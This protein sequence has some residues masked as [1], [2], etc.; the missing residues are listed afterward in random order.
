MRGGQE[1]FE[2][3]FSHGFERLQWGEGVFVRLGD[4]RVRNVPG[5]VRTRAQM[6]E[7]ERA[8]TQWLT[9]GLGLSAACGI[10]MIQPRD[11]SEV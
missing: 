10:R 5:V 11:K 7:R 6:G 9:R 4:E 1:I 3:C 2:T 8:M